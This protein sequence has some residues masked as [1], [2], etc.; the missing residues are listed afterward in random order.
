MNDIMIFILEG[1]G[2][3]DSEVLGEVYLKAQG[4]GVR[5]RWREQQGS[6]PILAEQ[7]SKGRDGS[8]ERRE[9]RGESVSGQCNA[10]RGGESVII[11]YLGKEAKSNP[12]AS[13]LQC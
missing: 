11:S 4:I 7:R 6:V 13:C 2:L 9:E 8:F 10:L 1:R 5:G 12:I 3:R